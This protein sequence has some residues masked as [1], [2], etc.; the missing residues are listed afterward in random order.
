M[1]MTDDLMAFT[2]LETAI[3]EAE[4]ELKTKKQEHE[5]LSRALVEQFEE[6]EDPYLR[7]EYEETLKRNGVECRMDPKWYDKSTAP[8][9][10]K[11]VV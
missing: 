5:R 3:R 7:R 10:M 1:A 9:N 8:A 2:A 11:D 6:M 4:A